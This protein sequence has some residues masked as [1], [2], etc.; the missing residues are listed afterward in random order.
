MTDV[1]WWM[2]KKLSSFPLNGYF[3]CLWKQIILE[4]YFKIFYQ[5]FEPFFFH[6]KDK[7]NQDRDE[8]ICWLKANNELRQKW[9]FG[10][11]LFWPIINSRTFVVCFGCALRFFPSKEL[12]YKTNQFDIFI[13][14]QLFVWRDKTHRWHFLT[15]S[16]DLILLLQS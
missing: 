2:P 13:Y 7:K 4:V 15:I 10:K 12:K 14:C 8:P 9:K 3:Y 6:L 5:K 16:N 11:F 1:C